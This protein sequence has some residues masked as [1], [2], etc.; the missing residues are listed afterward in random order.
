MAQGKVGQAKEKDFDSIVPKFTF[1]DMDEENR[2]CVVN[3]CRDAYKRHH[4]GEFKYFRDMAHCVKK[5]L[6]AHKEIG[7][8]W[9][10]VIGKRNVWLISV[11]APALAPTSPTNTR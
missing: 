1:C 8:A 10:V 4:D 7:G 6:D 5:Q 2:K 9:H 11:Q 3:M